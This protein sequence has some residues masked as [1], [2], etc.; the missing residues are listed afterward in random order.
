MNKT[1]LLVIALL[2]GLLPQARAQEA[3]DYFRA[4]CMSCHTIGGGRLT[5][6]DLKNVTTR[7]TREWLSTFMTDPRAQIDAGDPYALNLAKE[8]RGTIMPTLP[9]MT[10]ARALALLDLIDAESK[11]PKSAFAG[12]QVSDRPFTA[13]D[14]QRGHDIFTGAVSLVNGGPPCISCHNVNGLGGLG[15]GMFAPDLTTVFERYQG[16]KTLT[17]WL[18]AP[19]TP[20]MQATFKTHALDPEEIL[21]LVALFQS[22]LQRSPEDP[23]SARLNLVLFSLGS[24]LLALGLFDLGWGKRFT[25]V[26][27]ILVASRKLSDTTDG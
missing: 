12:V 20:T 21:A 19:A 18:S 6:P 1:T 25:A 2:A 23:S 7:N 22:T 10:K 9:T 16:R 13:N 3:A 24:T 11:L 17:T 14:V 27:R 8:A 15:G 5:G 26:R 4:N